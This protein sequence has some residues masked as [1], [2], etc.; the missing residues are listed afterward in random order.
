MRVY[1]GTKLVE[2]YC[3]QCGKKLQVKDDM[4]MDGV[5]AVDYKWGY[6]SKRDGTKTSFELCEACYEKLTE[7]FIYPAEEEDYHE[8]L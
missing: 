5:F 3:N 6:F 8:L 2:L 4:I 1:E 7:Q